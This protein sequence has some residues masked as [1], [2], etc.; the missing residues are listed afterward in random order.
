MD[1]VTDPRLHP[2]SRPHASR[3]FTLLELMM[4]IVVLGILSTLAISTYRGYRDRLDVATAVSDIA[5]MEAVIEQYVLDNRV[6]PA[7]L[8][9][10]GLDGRTDP[11]GHP[12]AYYP[13]TTR[14][15]TH[16]RMDRRLNPINTD[17]DLYSAGKDGQ[18]K[19]QLTNR[20]SLDDIVRANNG[21]FVGKAEDF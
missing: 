4:V 17:Y 1:A 2:L 13:H 12:Y 21:A 5:A 15:R 8:D 10:A 3:G 6:L 20:D 7:T 11:W 14:A 16:W 18:T 19:K 9:D